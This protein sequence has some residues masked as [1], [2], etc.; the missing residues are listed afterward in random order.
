MA[1][2][3]LAI[4][5]G[6][7][8]VFCLLGYKTSLA[9]Q[10]DHQ[11]AVKLDNQYQQLVEEIYLEEAN[12]AA[13]FSDLE[14]LWNEYQKNISKGNI[15]KSKGI[16]VANI[17]LFSVQ[18]DH[19]LVNAFVDDLMQ[20]NE[21]QLAETIYGKIESANASDSL[22]YLNYFFAKYYA[23]QRDWL[24]VNQLLSQ[25]PIN[26]AGKDADH[27]Y[28]LQGLSRQFLKQHRQS[29]ES[30]GSISRNSDY[31][32]HAR[33]NTALA[34]IR[35]GWIT[36]ARSIINKLIPVSRSLEKNELTN[37]MFVVLGYALLQQEYYR[38]AREAFGNVEPDNTYTNR[39]LFG[40]ALSAISQGD[41]QAGLNA[42]NLLKQ[43]NRDDLSRDEA[44]LLVP[45]I[46]ER[47]DEKLLVE[48]SFSTAINH[49]QARILELESL[50]NLSLNFT[51]MN[52][53]DSGALILQGL[54]L[55]FSQQ[56][57]AFLFTNRH[58]LYRLSSEVSNTDFSHRISSL[59]DQHDRLLN[60]IVTSLIDQQI[61]YLESY[62]NQVRYGLARH[63][64]NQNR[65]VQ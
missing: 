5:A 52:L 13:S 60:E 39:A 64:D 6:L 29:I 42:V 19:A 3:G 38:D 57:P 53:E 40:T 63:Y 37:R 9:E 23:R 8:I 25:I 41:L 32:V 18:P 1:V 16:I 47:L 54:E 59:A 11:L 20:Q 48:D 27:A 35:Q 43:S 51:K 10:N 62:L 12:H 49:Y 55:A 36:Q 26:L 24:Q 21:R 30:Y 34:N 14:L 44:Y 33:L 17:N 50:K 46:Y 22:S 28:L 58:N 15:A 65:D 4:K 61:A 2:R 56:H 45:Y 31:F 7:F